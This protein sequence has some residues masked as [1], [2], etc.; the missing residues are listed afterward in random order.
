MNVS[1]PLAANF[2]PRS[3]VSLPPI[4]VIVTASNRAAGT[5]T[6][7]EPLAALASG[8]VAVTV[9]P[10]RPGFTPYALRRPLPETISAVAGSAASASKVSGSP[11]ASVKCRPKSMAADRSP[12]CTVRSARS[13]VTAGTDFTRTATSSL[14]V[15][16]RPSAAR[17]VTVAVPN[18]TAAMV[19]SSVPLSTT[20]VATAGA[21]DS[22]P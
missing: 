1:V 19:S 7:N 20:A 4:F 8:S 11:S 6:V 5:V 13:F 3:I 17:T 22:A 16:P 2:A 18:A 10:V 21:D 12:T 15:P 14:P 9:T